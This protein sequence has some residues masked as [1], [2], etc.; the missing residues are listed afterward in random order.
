MLKKQAKQNT[1]KQPQTAAHTLQPQIDPICMAPLPRNMR[2]RRRPSKVR[3]LPDSCCRLRRS[4]PAAVSRSAMKGMQSLRISTSALT[5]V[6]ICASSA[7]TAPVSR[8]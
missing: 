6:T 2:S 8:H 7:R 3:S 5:A 4:L 1:Q